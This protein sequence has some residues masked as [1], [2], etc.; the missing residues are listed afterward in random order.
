MKQSPLDWLKMGPKG[1]PVERLAASVSA[2]PVEKKET[3]AQHAITIS[4]STSKS[5]TVSAVA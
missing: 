3:S 5:M 4:I 1:D 2:T